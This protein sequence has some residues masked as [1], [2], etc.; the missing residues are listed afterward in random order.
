MVWLLLLIYNVVVCAIYAWDKRK[1]KR[2]EWRV[3]ERTLLWLAAAGGGPGAMVGV[4]QLR[5]KSKKPKFTVG[6]SA[7]TAAQGALLVWGLAKGW[8]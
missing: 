8:W 6:V 5:H 3:S 2:S 1:A 7:L 4:F